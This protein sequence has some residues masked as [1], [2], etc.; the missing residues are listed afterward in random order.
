MSGEATTTVSPVDESGSSIT[1]TTTSTDPNATATATAVTATDITLP[2]Q[3]ESRS[4]PTI[5]TTTSSSSSNLPLNP[6]SE[7]NKTANHVYIQ[8]ETSSWIPAQVL[9]R[10]Q[11]TITNSNEE[12]GT[13]HNN[14]DTVIV[15]N[16]PLYASE[17]AIQ[18]DG[19]KQARKWERRSCDLKDYPNQALP[20]QNVNAEGTLQVV[21]DMVDLPFLHEVRCRLCVLH[22]FVVGLCECTGAPH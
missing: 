14:D 1:K 19:G 13:N 12:D 16:V 22:V 7:L 2:N 11:N 8:D 9:E 17:Q 4:S 20:L 21:E 10:P 15:V 6:S 5:T 3:E 18:C